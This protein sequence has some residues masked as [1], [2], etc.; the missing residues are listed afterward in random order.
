MTSICG[1][2]DINSLIGYRVLTKAFPKGIVP[3]GYNVSI[4]SPQDQYVF[5]L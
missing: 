3:F 2:E 5:N 1:F 4:G